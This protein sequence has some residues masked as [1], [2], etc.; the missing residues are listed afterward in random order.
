MIVRIRLQKIVFQVQ[1]KR[2]LI[3]LEVKLISNLNAYHDQ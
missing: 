1:F 3:R 2:H